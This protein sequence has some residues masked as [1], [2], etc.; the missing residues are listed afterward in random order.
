MHTNCDLLI[1]E[2]PVVRVLS[3]E[4]PNCLQWS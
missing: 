4:P 1:I 3:V 2:G